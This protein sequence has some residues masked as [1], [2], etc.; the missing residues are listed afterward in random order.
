MRKL[1]DNSIQ[2][3][4]LCKMD[5]FF[6]NENENFTACAVE[7]HFAS[8]AKINLRNTILSAECKAKQKSWQLLFWCFAAR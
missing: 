7:F 1:F 4:N 6:T 5:F 2:R 8:I 3:I